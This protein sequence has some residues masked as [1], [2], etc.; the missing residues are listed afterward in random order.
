MP[1]PTTAP[2]NGPYEREADARRDAAAVYQQARERHN[3]GVMSL[4]NI[5]AV[6]NALDAAEVELGTYDKR[7]VAWLGNWEPELVQA[8]IGW[9]SRANGGSR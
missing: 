2:P 7:I 9:I 8:V 6:L 3:P 1:D 4:L 5:E